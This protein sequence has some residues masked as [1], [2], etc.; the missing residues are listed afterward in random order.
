MAEQIFDA[1]LPW[2]GDPN[3]IRDEE[4]LAPYRL[5]TIVRTNTTTAYNHGRLTEF[6]DPEIIRFVKGIRY[7]AILDERTTPVCTFLDGLVFKPTDPNLEVLLPPNHYNAVVVGTPIKTQRG[8]IPIEQVDVGDLVLTHRGRWRKVYAVMS[9]HNESF[10]ELHLSTGRVLR[11]TDEHPILTRSGWLRAD[12]LKFG[13][14]LFQHGEQ[15]PGACRVG[16]RCPDDF[17]SLFDE[18][19]VAYES[20]SFARRTSLS[21]VDLKADAKRGPRKVDDISADCVLRRERVS[22]GDKQC[23]ERS[24]VFGGGSFPRLGATLRDLFH[25][26]VR[27]VFAAGPAFA[28]SLRPLTSFFSCAP[29]PVFVAGTF[30]DHFRQAVG[31]GDLFDTASYFDAES[32][33][34]AEQVGFSKGK[35]ALDGAHR[36]PVAPVTFGNQVFN[37]LFVSQVHDDP[38]WVG[39]AIIAAIEVRRRVEVWNLAVE[40]DETYHAEG[41]V[42]H[43]C[44]SIIVPI[45]AGEQVR[46]DE[47]ITPAQIGKARGLADAKFL[48]QDADVWRA[49]RERE[50]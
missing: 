5:E 43:N 7:S 45:V 4:Q 13:D 49:Y 27:W 26:A 29:S 50:D 39:A 10:R 30:G 8:D 2:L 6:L 28:R 46:E 34:H 11:V 35:G 22:I 15:V 21:V 9:K 16:V 14:K 33:A 37:G 40:E 3:V 36:F 24:F 41:I 20:I 23:G 31:D 47:F 48:A 19:A 17:P 1:F 18:D 42:V 44:R 38:R 12:G 32:F 25:A